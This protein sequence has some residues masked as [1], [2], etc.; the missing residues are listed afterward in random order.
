MRVGTM[1]EERLEAAPIAWLRGVGGSRVVGILYLWNNGE[2]SYM[3]LSRRRVRFIEPLVSAEILAK[4]K[5]TAPPEMVRLL[6]SLS[7]YEKPCG[8]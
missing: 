6:D 8:Q 1:K 3:W 5:S 7:V 2:L 4:A